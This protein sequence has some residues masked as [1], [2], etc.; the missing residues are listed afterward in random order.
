MRRDALGC[1]LD[2]CKGDHVEIVVLGQ[3]FIALMCGEF[4]TLECSG[5]FCGVFPKFMNC[6][7]VSIRDILPPCTTR[8]F[9][10]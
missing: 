2:V 3:P 4:H 6:V 9:D 10:V 1:G 5:F 7:M 8:L